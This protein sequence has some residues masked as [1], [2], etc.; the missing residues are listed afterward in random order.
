MAKSGQFVTSL[1]QLDKIAVNPF[2]P[3]SAKFTTDECSNNYFF[4]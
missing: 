4:K 3:D 2:P 1:L